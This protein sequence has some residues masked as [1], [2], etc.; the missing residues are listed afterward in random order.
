MRRRHRACRPGGSRMDDIDRRL[1]NRLQDGLP[2]CRRPFD[3]IAHELELEVS[4][5]LDRLRC[6]LEAGT[7]TR[8]GPMYNAEQLGGAL[9]LCAMQVPDAEFE[10]VAGQVNAHPEVAHN[11]ARDH[12]LNMWFVI[13]TEEPGQAADV[14]AIIERETGCRV[15]DMPKQEEFYIGLKLPV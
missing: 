9:S 4:A 5:V 1:V 2:V 3:E 10:R 15:Y 11:Y 12:Q 6:L 8:F 14:I 13:A 7:L